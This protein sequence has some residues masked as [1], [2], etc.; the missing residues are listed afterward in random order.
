LPKYPKKIA[1]I[2]SPTGA[3]IRDF[4]NVVRRRQANGLEVNLYP[5]RVQGDQ[6]ALEIKNAIE[7]I[8]EKNGEDLIVIA[9]GGGSIE[10]LWPFNENIVVEAIYHS[11][12]PVVSA[13]GHETDFTLSDFVSD[14]RASTPSVAGELVV[15]DSKGITDKIIS[16]TQTISYLL[17][18]N[19]EYKGLQLAPYKK[20]KLKDIFLRQIEKRMMDLDFIQRDLSELM[21]KNFESKKSEFIEIGGRKSS[22]V[23]LMSLYLERLS[24]QFEN[25]N[26][27]R[28]YQDLE[29]GII[30][31]RKGLH[32][33]LAQS[34]YRMEMI[35][36]DRKQR[37]EI[38]DERLMAHSP[39]GILSKGYTLLTSN[40]ECIYSV[41]QLD[42]GKSYDLQLSDGRA[43]VEIKEIYYGKKK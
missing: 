35:L 24:N 9:R 31:D 1:I 5:V 12:L 6:A 7:L 36:V 37:L 14:V 10:D 22:L 4:W 18:S 21:V 20:S 13:V 3:V 40:E 34:F 15:S 8:N 28:V 26:L 17:Q 33:I 25:I 41:D 42:H 16:Y 32:E 29:L 38:I 39:H 23:E 30:N 27:K 11:K 2:T 43:K 19:I